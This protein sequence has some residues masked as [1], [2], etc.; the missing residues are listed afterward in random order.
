MKYFLGLL[1]LCCSLSH[2]KN[3]TVTGSCVAMDHYEKTVY[4]CSDGTV[5]VMDHDNAT[6][7]RPNDS[8][9]T[10]GAQRCYRVDLKTGESHEMEKGVNK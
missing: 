8:A 10:G 4:Q 1:V 2:A 5:T 7:C 3:S 9:V 6:I